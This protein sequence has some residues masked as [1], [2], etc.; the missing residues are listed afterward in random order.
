M[1][2]VGGFFAAAAACGVGTGDGLRTFKPAAVFVSRGA[3][4]GGVAL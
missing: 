1:F 4:V 2:G 3:S